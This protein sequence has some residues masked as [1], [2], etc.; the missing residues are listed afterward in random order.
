MKAKFFAAHHARIVARIIYFRLK[1][2]FAPV[3]TIIAALILFPLAMS[4]LEV[5]ANPSNQIFTMRV[6][7]AAWAY[8]ARVI[9]NPETKHVILRIPDFLATGTDAACAKAA[10]LFHFICS[11]DPRVILQV[12]RINPKIIFNG[13]Y[14]PG[15]KDSGE[16]FKQIHWIPSK[17]N[18]MTLDWTR[19]LIKE[20]QQ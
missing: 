8:Q 11:L 14:D 3:A 16:Q 7:R 1:K 2:S 12:Y 19:E 10:E 6:Q 4:A 13:K 18:P 5:L 9:V 17:V 20:K 15:T